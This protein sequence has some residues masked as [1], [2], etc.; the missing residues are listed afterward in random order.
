LKKICDSIPILSF[1]LD[2]DICLKHYFQSEWI[3]ERE[4]ATVCNN[5][6]ALAVRETLQLGN[7]PFDK[8]YAVVNAYDDK[9]NYIMVSRLI[10][11]KDWTFRA[12][13]LYPR[14][15]IAALENRESFTYKLSFEILDV[16]TYKLI[17][18]AKP[19][20]KLTIISLAQI[21]CFSFVM[22]SL[23]I[24]FI[25]K[26]ALDQN[27]IE[28]TLYYLAGSLVSYLLVYKVLPQSIWAKVKKL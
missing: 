9:R 27:N 25:G 22:Q 8:V 26:P 2:V 13:C 12:N 11:D 14:T 28:I 6:I 21:V 18:P 7:I 3:R 4:P 5:P 10:N 16:S 1:G 24:I 15:L 17:H 19:L 20:W 23:F